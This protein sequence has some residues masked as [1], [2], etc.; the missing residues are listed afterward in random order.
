MCK[1]SARTCTNT[2]TKLHGRVHS[3]ETMRNAHTNR[4]FFLLFLRLQYVCVYRYLCAYNSLY[5][6]EEIK[7]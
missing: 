7:E 5:V 4:P 2:H 6:A 3:L 1:R